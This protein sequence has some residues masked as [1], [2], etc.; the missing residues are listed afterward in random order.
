[1]TSVYYKFP[2]NWLTSKCKKTC[3][4]NVNVN[5]MSV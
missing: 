1:M 5:T 2:A 3:N 4:V